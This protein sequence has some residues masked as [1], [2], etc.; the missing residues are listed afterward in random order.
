MSNKI[1]QQSQKISKDIFSSSA[2]AWSKRMKY[3]DEKGKEV[4]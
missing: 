1:F 2:Q 4:A 3:P